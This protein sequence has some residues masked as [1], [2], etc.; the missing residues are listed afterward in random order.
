MDSLDQTTK[1]NKMA[2]MTIAKHDKPFAA[3]GLISYRCKA[4]Y[5]WIMIGAT[6]DIDAMNEARRS[7]ETVNRND[8]Q[9]WNGVKY[10]PA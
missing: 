6:D 2:G 10:V 8:L 3:V 5:G 1:G 9:K 4:R 7:S